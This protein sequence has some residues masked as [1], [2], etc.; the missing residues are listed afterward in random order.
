[1][2]STRGMIS[3]RVLCVSVRWCLQGEGLEAIWQRHTDM[4]HM[5]WDGLTDMGLEPYVPAEQDRLV[6]VNTIKVRRLSPPA[7]RTTPSDAELLC[8]L[9][10]SLVASASMIACDASTLSLIHI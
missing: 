3:A 7:P 1:M 8:L 6:T 4:H 2:K 5:L 10:K 9:A